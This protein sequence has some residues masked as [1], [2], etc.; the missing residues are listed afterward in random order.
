[1]NGF[2]IGFVESWIQRVSDSTKLGRPHLDFN[3]RWTYDF[4]V[5]K[6]VEGDGFNFTGSLKF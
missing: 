1:M 5:S 6:R 4:D 3:A 2:G